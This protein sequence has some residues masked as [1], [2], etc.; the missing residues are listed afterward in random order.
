MTP[1]LNQLIE[2]ENDLINREI[3]SILN[4]KKDEYI[5]SYNIDKYINIENKDE[6]KKIDKT[7]K[8]YMSAFSKIKRENLSESD[9]IK[10]YNNKTVWKK[11]KDYQVALLESNGIDYD[12]IIIYAQQILLENPNVARNYRVQYKHICVDEA[13]DLN[14]SQYNFILSTRQKNEKVC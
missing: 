13:Q 5:E 11:F 10:E 1:Q 2:Y 6:R 14:K 4:S 12:D 9:V 3:Q 7:L 8:D